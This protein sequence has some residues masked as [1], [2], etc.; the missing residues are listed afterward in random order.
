LPGGKRVNAAGTSVSVNVAGALWVYLVNK[1]PSYTYQQVLDLL[2]S[3]S[4]SISTSRVKGKLISAEEIVI[5]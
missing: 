1:N 3:K 2:N 5:G 4:V